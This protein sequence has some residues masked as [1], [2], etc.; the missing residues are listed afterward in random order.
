[1]GILDWFKNRPGQFDPDRISE[2]MVRRAVDNAIALTNPRIKLLPN[3]HKRLTP[4]VEKTIE[5]LRA[6]V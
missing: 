6:Q 3:C 1:M 4:A 2:E 5:F